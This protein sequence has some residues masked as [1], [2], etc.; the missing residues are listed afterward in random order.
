M[1][2]GI[3]EESVGVEIL[4]LEILLLLLV[5]G[6]AFEPAQGGHHGEQEVEFGVLRDVRLDEDGRLLRIESGGEPVEDH[7]E[8]VCLDARG[9]SVVGGEGVPVGDKEKTVVVVLEPG[10]VLQGTDVVADV[11]LAGRSHAA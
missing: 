8:D 3:A 2:D 1:Q 10:P 6:H 11:Q 4:F 9:V 7:L 5:G